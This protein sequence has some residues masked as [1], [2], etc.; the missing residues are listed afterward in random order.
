[1]EPQKYTGKISGEYPQD[2]QALYKEPIET[3]CYPSFE[4]SKRMRNE[5]REVSTPFVTRCPLR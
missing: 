1:M 5:V 2:Y 3:A 4:L